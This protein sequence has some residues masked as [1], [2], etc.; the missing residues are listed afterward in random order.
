MKLEEKH[1]ELLESIWINTR[2]ERRDTFQRKDL[3]EDGNGIVDELI[4]AGYV[5]VLDGQIDLTSQGEPLA[6]NVIR[7]HR[8]AERLLADVLDT[9]VSIMDEKA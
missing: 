6:R 7:R 2:E 5:R 8:L 3:G 4:T 1:E 9:S